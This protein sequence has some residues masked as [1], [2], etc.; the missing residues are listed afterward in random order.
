MFYDRR[1]RYHAYLHSAGW[2][3][4][5][6]PVRWRSGGRCERCRRWRARE[7][8]HL[9]YRRIF[10]ELPEDLIHLC[11]GCHERMHGRQRPMAAVM[12]IALMIFILLLMGLAR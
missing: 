9:T 3:A 5:S 10:R 2:F 7:V 6:A 11:V 1:Q 12:I 8:H 4:R